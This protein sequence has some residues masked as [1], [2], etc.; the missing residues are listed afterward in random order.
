MELTYKKGS[1]QLKFV[2]VS[3]QE[4]NKVR[5]DL[6]ISKQELATFIICIIDYEEAQYINNIRV[7]W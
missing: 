6:H 5:V 3:Y 4:K 2:L 1:Q 7:P